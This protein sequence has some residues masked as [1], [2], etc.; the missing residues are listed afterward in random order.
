MAVVEGLWY[1]STRTRERALKPTLTPPRELGPPPNTHWLELNP[2]D[3]IALA[4]LLRARD[5]QRDLAQVVHELAPLHRLAGR[6]RGSQK[7]G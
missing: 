6:S 5:V 2:P 3:L 7:I 1:F 4:R